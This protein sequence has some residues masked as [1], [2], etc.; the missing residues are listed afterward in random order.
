MVRTAIDLRLG[1]EG[2]GQLNRQAARLAREARDVSGRDV[3]VGGS[4]GPLGSAGARRAVIGEASARAAFREQIEGLLEGGVD[5][6][7]L[8]T[9]CDLGQLL[10]AMD[11]ARRPPTCRSS[12]R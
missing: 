7:L 6:L 11:E 4:I 2:A 5:L 12:P 3:L 9:F 1:P 8:E 10:L